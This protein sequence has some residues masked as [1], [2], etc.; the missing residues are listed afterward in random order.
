MPP[1]NGDGPG[2][3]TMANKTQPGAN[4]SKGG[5]SLKPMCRRR[6]PDAIALVAPGFAHGIAG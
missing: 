6:L 3:R 1:V 2:A 5:R 4:R